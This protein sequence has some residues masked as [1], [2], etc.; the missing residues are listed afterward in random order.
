MQG[1]QETRS[2]TTHWLTIEMP[3]SEAQVLK[4]YLNQA[5][6]AYMRGSYKGSEHP[7]TA[8][9]H[10]L[11]GLSNL[12]SDLIAEAMKPEPIYDDRGSD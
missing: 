3:L 11:V 10:S 8:G 9:R 12:L 2:V 1:S 4:L 7:T 6:S 5:I